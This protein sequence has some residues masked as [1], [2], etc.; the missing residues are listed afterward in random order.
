M[1]N[2]HWQ[3]DPRAQIH[4]VQPVDMQENSDGHASGSSADMQILGLQ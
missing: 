1:W 3:P 2:S 4:G